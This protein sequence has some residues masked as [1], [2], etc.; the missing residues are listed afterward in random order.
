L[1]IAVQLRREPRLLLLAALLLLLAGSGAQ[2]KKLTVYAAQGSTSFP[3]IDR[4]GVEYVALVDI[5]EQF[6]TAK[7]KQS[8]SKFHLKF[9]PRSGST[10]EAEFN[11]NSTAAKIGGRKIELSSPFLIL[12]DR[13]LVPT[14]SLPQLASSFLGIPVSFH[15]TA[16]RLF[17]GAVSNPFTY[18]LQK[19]GGPRLVLHFSAPVSPSIATEPGHLRMTFG[20]DPV[21]SNAPAATLSDSTFSSL[22][23]SEA[24]G[25]AEISVAATSPLLASFSDGGRTVTITAQ[26]SAPAVSS[27]WN[28]PTTASPN[29]TTVP[30]PVPTAPRFLI[31]IDAAHGGTDPGAAITPTVSEKDVVL[32]F[33]RRLKTAL[34]NQGVATVLLR[35]S[36][37]TLSFDQR[38]AAVNSS[39]AALVISVHATSSSSALHVYTA[40][41]TPMP[42]TPFVPWDTAQAAFLDQSQ[43]AAGAISKEL[44]TRNISNSSLQ[45]SLRPLNSFAHPTVAIELAP[46][47]GKADSLILLSYQQPIVSAV[48]AGIADMR[49]TLESPR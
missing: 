20:K 30:V 2:D 29:L 7:T 21:V 6:G 18:D 42:R 13:G 27:A 26:Q 35:D 1:N 40:L 3:V 10:I 44:F 32:A 15:Q 11:Q 46:A 16:R 39:H 45:A 36:D 12:S 4:N 19:A 33:A 5:L 34:D 37:S 49:S 17:V 48:A 38:T 47:N 41:L 8:D 23:Y 28:L 31:V 43:A 25:A 14:S 9:A 22:S 24:N